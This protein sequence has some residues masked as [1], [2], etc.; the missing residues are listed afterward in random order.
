MGK[1][2]AVLETL[3]SK[4]NILSTYSITQ[5]SLEHVFI[6]MASESNSTFVEAKVT[7]SDNG[8]ELSPQLNANLETKTTIDISSREPTSMNHTFSMSGVIQ[9]VEGEEFFL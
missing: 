8:S 4:R 5:S 3:K 1:A 6:Q 7:K 9:K 2:F